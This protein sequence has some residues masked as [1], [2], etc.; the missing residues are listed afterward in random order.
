M[1]EKKSTILSLYPNTYGVAYAL[2][3]SPKKLV[4]YGLGQIRPVNSKKSRERIQKYIDYYKPDVVLLRGLSENRTHKRTLQL[5]N[6]IAHEVSAQG[7]QVYSYTREQIKSTFNEFESQ[8]QSKYQISQKIIE[9]YPQME[10]ISFP[11]PKRWMSENFNAGIFD[12]VSLAIAFWY[13]E[14]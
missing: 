12:A 9:W 7:L 11:I 1:K 6:Q 5:I 4:S 2:F 13:L 10:N 8:P 3:D 14:K